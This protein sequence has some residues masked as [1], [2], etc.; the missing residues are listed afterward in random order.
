MKNADFSKVLS[1]LEKLPR[2][3]EELSPGSYAVVGFN[4][5]AASPY[6]GSKNGDLYTVRYNI[7]WALLLANPI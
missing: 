1:K 2:L 5:T 7:Q 4:V 6:A 3:N